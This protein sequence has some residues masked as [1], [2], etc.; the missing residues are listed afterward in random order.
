MKYQ[1]I[2]EH[3][4]N[5]PD[6]IVLQKGEVVKVG[7][8]YKGPENWNNWI[9]CYTLDGRLEEIGSGAAAGHG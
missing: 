6:P 5:Y 2:E 1:V 8:R 4:T 7:E 9:Y 3:L